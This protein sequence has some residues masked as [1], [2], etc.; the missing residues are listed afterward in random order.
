MPEQSEIYTFSQPRKLFVLK[1]RKL[2]AMQ[3]VSESKKVISFWKLFQ[4]LKNFSMKSYFL[5]T[6]AFAK[7]KVLF[8]LPFL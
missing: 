3:K 5:L 8:Y 6:K 1:Q 2:F 4:S 7:E